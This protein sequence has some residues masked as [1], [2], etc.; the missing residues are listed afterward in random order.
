MIDDIIMLKRKGLSFRKIAKELGTT[1]GKVQYQWVK[2][3][4]GKPVESK[5]EMQKESINHHMQAD[6]M[7]MWMISSDR[8][9]IYWSLPKR[10]RQFTAEYFEIESTDDAILR[11]YDVTDIIFN[12]KN[13]HF[14]HELSL[15]VAQSNWIISGLKPNR[16]YVSE[17]GMRLTGGYFLPLLRSNAVHVPRT[18]RSQAGNLQKELVHYLLEQGGPPNWVEHVSTYSYYDREN[19]GAK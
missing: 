16:C 5:K 17:I 19:G 1:V 13:A 3:I 7:E 15:S 14:I 2:L 12:G 11:I 4:N 18:D 6:A 9:F 10:K 8:A